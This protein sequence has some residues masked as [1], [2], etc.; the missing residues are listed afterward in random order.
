MDNKSVDFESIWKCFLEKIKME[1]APVSFDMWFSNDNTKL[2]D[3]NE[4][5][6]KILVSSALHKRHIKDNYLDLVEK[7]FTDVTGSIFKFEFI[8]EQ[9]LDNQSIIDVDEIGV[10][11]NALFNSNL[12]PKYTFENF[13]IGA[14]NKFAKAAA[15][16]VAEQ[17][18]SMYNPLFIFG[19]SGLGKTHL[20]QAIGNYIKENS[21]KKVLYVT[22]DA[23]VNDFLKLHRSTE[24]DNNF[25]T[26]DNFKE[27]YRNVDVLIIDDIQYLE[28]A[29]KTQQEFFNTF[30]ELH[31]NNKQI[32]LA[33]DRSPDDLKKLEERLRTRFFWGLIVN[34]LPPDYQLRMDIIDNKI[35]SNNLK[36]FFPQEVK[37]Y[38]A[39]I[40]T[41]DIRKLE[42]AITRITA[43]ATIMNGSDITLDLAVEALSDSFN[44]SIISKNRIE[45][46]QQIVANNYKISIEDLKGKK[47]SNDITIPRQIAMYICRIYLQ[48]SL[49]KIGS[50]FGGK[51]HTTVMH[52]VNKIK[53]DI[54]QND[55]LAKEINKILN[56]I[57]GI[58]E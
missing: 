11:E 28:M 53:K 39:N 31:T 5:Y 44:K 12:D 35:D 57:P 7:T 49:P 29:H 38:I 1:L 9:E 16:S 4:E 26:V 50:E 6:A 15:L 43:F 58:N 47:K 18:G 45:Q 22:T 23:F 36:K 30:N 32:I 48:E 52:A 3:L 46:V 33:S 24:N 17:P 54:K 41:T 20:M 42:G 14:S 19:K 25:D 51:D 2:I 56:L 13:I 8:T 37:E 55:E 27:K 40:C 21:R 34:I 10:P